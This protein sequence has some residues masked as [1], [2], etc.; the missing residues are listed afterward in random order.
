MVLSVYSSQAPAY[1][2]LDALLLF[3]LLYSQGP[4]VLSLSFPQVQDLIVSHLN[5]C[6]CGV[7]KSQNPPHIICGQRRF[8]EKNGLD[9]LNTLN[10][11][12]HAHTYTHCSYPTTYFVIVA[13][14]LF[15]VAF[16]FCLFLL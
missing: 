14:S 8:G 13:V 10:T 6:I 3:L 4:N 1:C 16:A 2:T 11:T 15:H 12:T 7:V 9:T 5:E